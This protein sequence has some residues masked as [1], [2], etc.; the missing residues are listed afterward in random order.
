MYTNGN[1]GNTF[2]QYKISY[3]LLCIIIISM[4]E[5]YIT[6]PVLISTLINSVKWDLPCFAECCC[7][8]G[9]VYHHACEGWSSAFCG[10]LSATKLKRQTTAPS[11]TPIHFC[12]MCTSP[13]RSGGQTTNNCRHWILPKQREHAN[14]SWSRLV[15]SDCVWK[16]LVF[17]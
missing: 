7:G 3:I 13:R 2:D 1:V 12:W 5:V 6:C 16:A 14:I 8:P 10:A 4:Q 11:A 17:C 15:C 9:G